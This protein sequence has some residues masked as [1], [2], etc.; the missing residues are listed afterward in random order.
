MDQRAA[1]RRY[2]WYLGAVAGGFAAVQLL[3]SIVAAL[4]NAGNI[5]SAQR[6]LENGTADPDFLVSP[7]LPT[8]VASYLGMIVTGAIMLYLAR[9]AG[10]L[11]AYV[12]GRREAGVIAGGWV[13]LISGLIWIVL[14]MVLILLVHADGTL[15]GILT[16]NPGGPLQPFELTG[17]LVQ[18]LG[19]G[20]IGW[21][22]GSLLGQRG[23]DSVP[24][25]HAPAQRPSVG[26]PSATPWHPMEPMEWQ[27]PPQ[28]PAVQPGWPASPA[29][30]PQA[31]P[32]VAS[33]PITT[34]RS[35]GDDGDPASMN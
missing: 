35:N 5:L 9:R 26:A 2:G 28:T 20:L 21:G 19:A 30:S 1:A 12:S 7:L 23:A 22:L 27:R 25:P 8:V 34:P 4:A 31:W 18:E 29:E 6:A 14:S 16:S 13:A 32:P 24:L 3:V 10:Q 17:L 15:T 11:A 33:H